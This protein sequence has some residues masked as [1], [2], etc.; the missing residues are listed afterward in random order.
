MKLIKAARVYSC[1]LPSLATINAILK[2]NEFVP[3]CEKESLRAGFEPVFG[4]DFAFSFHSGYAFKLRYD[5]KIMPSAVIKEKQAARVA[6]IENAENRALPSKERMAVRDDV[7][8]DMLS[9]AFVKTQRITC[10]Y[11][12]TN[13][14]LFVPTSSGKLADIVTSKLIKAIGSIKATTIYCDGIKQSLSSKLQNYL[15]DE[16]S[17]EGIGDFLVDGS[18]KLKAEGGKTLAVKGNDIVESKDAILEALDQGAMVTELALTT[19]S[20][21]FRIGHD[22]VLRGVSFLTDSGEEEPDFECEEDKFR[23]IAGVHVLLLSDVVNKLKTL[24]EYKEP[25]QDE[26]IPVHPS[27]GNVFADLGRPDAEEALARVRAQ[28]DAESDLL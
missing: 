16:D 13:K 7:I 1:E 23:T 19:E 8:F 18:C 10:F 20:V 2:E 22:F 3:L 25:E 28:M 5:E 17:V 14:H 12:P 4:N 24:F 9:Q 26:D 6:E 15:V 11:D 27:S 21:Y